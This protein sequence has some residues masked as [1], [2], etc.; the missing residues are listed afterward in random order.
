MSN[1]EGGPS[2]LTSE[3][4]EQVESMKR[5][6][7]RKLQTFRTPQMQ[8]TILSGEERRLVHVALEELERANRLH[9]T[10][11]R[12]GR[13]PARYYAPLDVPLPQQTEDDVLRQRILNALWSVPGDGTALT[14]ILPGYP[15]DEVRRV[16]DQL[17][18]EGIVTVRR[19]GAAGKKA[20]Y[21]LS[22]AGRAHQMLENVVR[23]H[24]P[25]QHVHSLDEAL[26]NELV[27]KMPPAAK[28]EI[29]KA[30]WRSQLAKGGE[31]AGG[32]LP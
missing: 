24:V 29:V 1:D 10:I 3:E 20:I 27:A 7:E 4:R 5:R 19:L 6:I 31:Q 15:R 21:S 9:S 12:T 11:V 25:E 16:L 23:S 32:E 8:S 22:A 14:S 13:K 30:W 17:E 26:L 18:A 28:D 2:S